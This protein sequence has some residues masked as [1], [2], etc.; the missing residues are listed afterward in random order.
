MVLFTVVA[1]PMMFLLFCVDVER[2]KNLVLE[3]TLVTTGWSLFYGPD[4][5]GPDRTSYTK[6]RT[7]GPDHILAPI[8]T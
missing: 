6:I 3:E 1:R 4:Q 5:H 8:N 2:V 7:D